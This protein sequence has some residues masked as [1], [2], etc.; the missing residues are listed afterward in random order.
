MNQHAPNYWTASVDVTY[1]SN[2]TN[3]FQAYQGAGLGLLQAQQGPLQ[4]AYLGSL[5]S[6]QNVP[7]Q[8]AMSQMHQQ[9]AIERDRQ[10]RGEREAEHRAMQLLESRIGREAV[11]RLMNGGGYPIKSKIHDG[12]TFL[13]P[14]SGMVKIVDRRGRVTAESCIITSR[15]LP[16]PD[17]VLQ[18]ITAIEADETCVYATG[19]ITNRAFPEP[20][21][22]AVPPTNFRLPAYLQSIFA[23]G[24]LLGFVAMCAAVVIATG[25]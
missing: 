10:W 16:W 21:H 7:S 18:R 9:A 8:E 23:V 24:I 11:T 15:A 22:L 12:V 14:K 19:N 13:I 17:L 1:A 6:L 20:V 2:N 3:P 4:Q 5:A 25:G